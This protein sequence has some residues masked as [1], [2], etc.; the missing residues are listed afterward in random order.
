[1]Y[2]LKRGPKGSRKQDW[3]D[4]GQ[5]GG[6]YAATEYPRS[7][8]Q[9]FRQKVE[10]SEDH[11]INPATKNE[12]FKSLGWPTGTEVPYTAFVLSL[13]LPKI[14]AALKQ[15]GPFIKLPAELETL[16]CYFMTEYCT[17][18]VLNKKHATNDT[19]WNMF[20][21]LVGAGE[22]YRSS[23]V[24]NLYRNQYLAHKKLRK[25]ET[26][27][28]VFTQIDIGVGIFEGR[29]RYRFVKSS[30][31]NYFKKQEPKINAAAKAFRRWAQDR[32]IAPSLYFWSQYATQMP[33][34][35]SPPPSYKMLKYQDSIRRFLKSG[36]AP[37]FKDTMVYVIVLLPKD[38]VATKMLGASTRMDVPMVAGY[39]IA[40][41]LSSPVVAVAAPTKAA[42][43]TKTAAAPKTTATTVKAALRQVSGPLVP[44]IVR[45]SKNTPYLPLF[46]V[47]TEDGHHRETHEIALPAGYYLTVRDNAFAASTGDKVLLF[48]EFSEHRLL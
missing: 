26:L 9:M 8:V 46:P 13:A 10:L 31:M 17:M 45:V 27:D 12:L 1:M 19:Y 34:A 36:Y 16:F 22:S 3:L 24:T 18:S 11:D 20:A 30:A 40:R 42:G 47:S 35:T 38:D 2:L 44:V 43:P 25:V 5:Y 48:G 29:E 7:I 37:T 21:G 4:V 28:K 32:A 33:A 6:K 15:T 39:S 41:L 23:A 14:D